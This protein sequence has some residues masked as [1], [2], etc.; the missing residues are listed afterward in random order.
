MIY[1]CKWLKD[2]RKNLFETAGLW[3]P[4]YMHLDK[5]TWLFQSIQLDNLS[6]Q[7]SRLVI[8]ARHMLYVAR[9]LNQ[10]LYYYT[11]FGIYSYR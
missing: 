9:Y 6:E 4:P 7:V 1:E 3:N 2:G 11:M 8:L 10:I 5:N